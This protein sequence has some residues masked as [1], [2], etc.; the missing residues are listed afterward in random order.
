[1]RLFYIFS[2]GMHKKSDRGQ[3]MVGRCRYGLGL[4]KDD[5]HRNPDSSTVNL[6][7]C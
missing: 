3:S 2:A 4:T 5:E 7:L 1:M 6:Q